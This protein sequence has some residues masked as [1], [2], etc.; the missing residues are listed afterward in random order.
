MKLVFSSIKNVDIFEPEF[1]SLPIDK[2]TIEFK[3]KNTPGGL[4][5]VYAPNG[6]G[7]SSLTKVLSS[8][9]TTEA[10]AFSATDEVGRPLTPE[11][12][13]FHIIPDQINRNVIRGKETDYLIGQQIRREYELRDHIN[14]SVKNCSQKV[15]I[16]SPIMIRRPVVQGFL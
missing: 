12:K 6:T 7:K 11:S 13:V 8:E 1:Q 5:V 3:H 4:A 15:S 2:G 14:A 10:L 9:R 16:E